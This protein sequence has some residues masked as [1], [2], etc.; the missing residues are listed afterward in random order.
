MEICVFYW[1]YFKYNSIIRF[2]KVSKKYFLSSIS[3]INKPQVNLNYIYYSLIIVFT[4]L[5]GFLILKNIYYLDNFA[6]ALILP[7]SAL[8][9]W[10]YGQ[11]NLID[12][13]RVGFILFIT[14]I[15]LLFYTAVFQI[16]SSLTIFIAN[17]VN[18][19]MFGWDIPVPAFASLQCIFFII[20]APIVNKGLS[21]L[22]SRGYDLS[23]LS[24][25]PIG[26]AIG[27][28]GFI[29]FAVG[30]YLAHKFG[31]C[32]MIWIILGNIFLGL[33]E[34]FLY[35]PIL[36]AIATFSPIRWAGTFMGIFSI[37][38]AL[39]SFLSGKLASFL[40]NTWTIKSVSTA[41]ILSLSYVKISMFLASVIIVCIVIFFYLSHWY[42]Q[43]LALIYNKNN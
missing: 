33:G 15:L 14:L 24:R 30:E 35:P 37:S 1:D 34:V 26:L 13:K 3:T 5:V 4:I 25:I 12:K 19:D 43:E 31:G 21:L 29:M 27:T 40:A 9:I 11:I 17:Y 23:L 39:S 16:Y 2:F 36:T 41:S 20:F 18:R 8:L 22:A 42:K 7:F 28:I 10:L 38:L 32:G 6:Y